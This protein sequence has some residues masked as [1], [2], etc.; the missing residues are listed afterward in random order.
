MPTKIPIQLWYK[1][2]LLLLVFKNRSNI[3][4]F[5]F[6]E[7]QN[8]FW[9]FYIIFKQIILL[10]QF[11]R[12]YTSFSGLFQHIAKHKPQNWV[13]L[14]NQYTSNSQPWNRETKKRHIWES[15]SWNN[16]NS[17]MNMK[18]STWTSNRL[19]QNS[20]Y[21]QIKLPTHFTDWDIDW[22]S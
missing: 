14:S 21:L 12:H 20:S 15:F 13:A 3:L 2:S 10:S 8:E 6:P 22:R 19:M 5:T 7:T 17:R 16:F 1:S 9:T 18:S 4:L 11:M